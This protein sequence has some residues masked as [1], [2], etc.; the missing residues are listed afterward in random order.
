M[1]GPNNSIGWCDFTANP[2]SGKCLHNCLDC[3]AERIRVRY[4]KP[5]KIEFHPNWFDVR[6]YMRF[7]DKYKRSPRIF[8]G[9]THDL[10][11]DWI[12]DKEIQ[13]IIDQCRIA[14]DMVEPYRT[15]Y[16]PQFLF[17]T[18]NPKRYQE[19]VWPHNCWLGT[20]VRR[21]NELYRIDELLV[22][23]A[24]IHFVSLEPLLES[25]A[26]HFTCF[27]DVELGRPD[28]FI[29][30]CKTPY[31]KEFK[32]EWADY[33]VAACVERNIPIWVKKLPDKK[34]KANSDMA[35]WPSWARRRELP[36]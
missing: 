5:E 32:I 9:S 20:T 2:I 24:R 31:H 22:A 13:M 28:W 36:K 29:L 35:Q 14:E 7:V 34:G 23:Q 19:F 18:Q 26:G 12:R 30:G 33:V 8:V 27:L 6:Q 1:N 25:L 21:V 15:P 10:F 3:Y 4:G 17:L 11:G 16:N